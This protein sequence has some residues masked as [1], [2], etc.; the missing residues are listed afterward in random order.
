MYAFY[1]H[2]SHVTFECL[3]GWSQVKSTD[4]VIMEG[5]VN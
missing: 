1:M 4:Q 5:L 2:D 3:L